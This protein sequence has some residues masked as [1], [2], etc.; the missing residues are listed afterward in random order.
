[1]LP[2]AWLTIFSR[3]GEIRNE[4]FTEGK[5]YSFSTDSTFDHSWGMGSSSALIANLA[6]WAEIG[7]FDLFHLL[8]KG[9][10]YDVAAALAEGP[11][12]FSTVNRKER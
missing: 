8:Y 7:P 3:I 4:L 10:G 2:A 9:S 12:L 1:M 6:R 11:I 5:S